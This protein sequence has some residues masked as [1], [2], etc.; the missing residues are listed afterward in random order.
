MCL[1][2]FTKTSRFYEDFY[3]RNFFCPVMD[4]VEIQE[5]AVRDTKHGRGIWGSG[6]GIWGRSWG[7]VGVG[8]GGGG[9]EGT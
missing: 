2:G 1:L 9:G 6:R 5:V 8:D 3:I 7:L 4:S